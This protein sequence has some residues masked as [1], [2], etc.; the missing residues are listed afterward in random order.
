[1]RKYLTNKYGKHRCNIREHKE[2]EDKHGTTYCRNEAYP[3]Q[4]KGHLQEWKK[5]VHK[6]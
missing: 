5:N 1:M 4:E 6:A 2:V 3:G